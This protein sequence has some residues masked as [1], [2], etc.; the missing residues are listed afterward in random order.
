MWFEVE[1]A[2]LRFI[3]TSPYRFENTAVLDAP[4]ARV[5]EIWATGEGQAEWFQD[6]KSIRWTT[7][8]PYGVGSERVVELKALAVKERFLVWEPGKR[9]AFCMYAVTLPLLKAMV[10]D[11]TFEPEG[12]GKT[13]FTWRAHYDPSLLT[14][15]IHPIVRMIFSKLFANSTRGLAAYVKAHP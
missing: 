7:P 10:E 5:F 6:F 9:M 1:P 4:P 2:P 12:E 14:R 8:E 3:E 15:L 11:L 13:R